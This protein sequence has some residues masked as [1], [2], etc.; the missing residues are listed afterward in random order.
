MSKNDDFD[1]LVSGIKDETIEYFDKLSDDA[2][3]M[4][5]ILERDYSN[6]GVPL[7]VIDS[8]KESASN[9]LKAIDGVLAAHSA[10][11][12]VANYGFFER[13]FHNIL[14]I[15]NFLSGGALK[16]SKFIQRL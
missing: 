16:R 12:R 1:M 11:D 4:R 5:L 15:V 3:Q 9:A 14:V 13:T 7:E 8:L 10:A 2:A 6:S